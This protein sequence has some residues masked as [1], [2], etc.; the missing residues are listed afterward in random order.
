MRVKP[1]LNAI[2]QELSETV[3]QLVVLMVEFQTQMQ[4]GDGYVEATSLFG[5]LQI[6]LRRELSLYTV[7]LY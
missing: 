3:P 2:Q 4:F 1:L 7:Q 6:T 5:H